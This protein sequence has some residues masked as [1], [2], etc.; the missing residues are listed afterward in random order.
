[1]AVAIYYIRSQTTNFQMCLILHCLIDIFRIL[2]HEF[3]SQISFATW[4]TMCTQVECGT[5]QQI[6]HR[7]SSPVFQCLFFS[8][9]FDLLPTSIL[10]S[11]F[12]KQSFSSPL[13]FTGAS[14][15]PLS[16][17]LGDCRLV[18]HS[19]SHTILLGLLRVPSDNLDEK[20]LNTTKTNTYFKFTAFFVVV[21][22]VPFSNFVGIFFVCVFRLKGE[23]QHFSL[24]FI[25]VCAFLRSIH[26]R[27]ALAFIKG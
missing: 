9:L 13:F 3:K 19:I 21:F 7:I 24:V 10:H 5:Q 25:V 11:S 23:K 18:R 14:H 26:G 1:M 17:A 22:P 8:L 16:H 2:I 6:Q 27:W 12:G 15:S 4:Q 20:R